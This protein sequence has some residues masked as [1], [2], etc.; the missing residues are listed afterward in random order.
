MQFLIVRVDLAAARKGGYAP[1]RMLPAPPMQLVCRVPRSAA[2]A[3]IDFVPSSLR[4]TA[5]S[6]YSGVKRC[7]LLFGGLLVGFLA[8]ALLRL[9]S[10]G[11]SRCPPNRVKS[12]V[13][14][15]CFE[16]ARREAVVRGACLTVV[17]KLLR[18]RATQASADCMRLHAQSS[19]SGLN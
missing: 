1:V 15:R 6:L 5:S 2:T 16:D 7:R 8:T 10:T 4:R 19:R 9:S 17:S 18:T 14:K 12:M 3:A 11:L 13:I